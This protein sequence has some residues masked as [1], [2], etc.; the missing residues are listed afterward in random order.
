M[1]DSEDSHNLDSLLQVEEEFRPTKEITEQA[2]VKSND[3]YDFAKK[4]PEK[5]W[6]EAASE[7]AWFRPWSKILEWNQPDARWFIDGK[8]NVSFNCLDRHIKNWRRNKVAIFWEGELGDSR[9]LTYGHLYSEVSKFANVLK[10]L[11]LKKGDRATIYM[12]MLPELPISMLAC[13]R[14][15]VIH[16]VVFSGLGVKALQD[17]IKDVESKILITANHG[18]RRGK[19]IPLKQNVDEALLGASTIEKVV[20]YRRSDMSTSIKEGRDYWWHDLVNKT[21]SKCESEYLDSE[22]PLFILHTS[23]TTGKPKGIVHLNGGYLVGVSRTQKWVFDIKDED[24]F[25]CTADIGWITGHSYIVYGPLALGATEVMYE[26]SPDYPYPD[27]FWN[28]IEKYGVTVF[29]TAPTAI[30][31]FMRLGE[32]W[33]KKHD[34]SSLRLLGTVGEPINMKAWLWYRSIIGANKCP[35]VDTW[36]QTETGMIMISPLP[37]VTVTKPGSATVP[38]PG[39]D[40]DVLDEKG[41]PTP[42]NQ[43]GFL[44]IKNPWPSMLKTIYKNQERYVETYWNPIPGVYFTGDSARK[45]EKGYFWIMGRVDD[46]IKVSGHRLGTMELEDAISSYPPVAES[47]VVGK[48]HSI[49]GQSITA[50]V[51]LKEGINPNVDLR[52]E[53]KKYV[54]KEIGPIATPDEIFFVDK[55]PK[56]R[57]GKIMRRVIRALVIGKDLGDLTTLEDPTAVEEV[58][59]WLNTAG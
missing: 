3:I 12:P 4:N 54:R 38:F 31:E 26:G 59:K 14:I 48:P 57:S 33:P 56:T 20:I 29:Y 13:A 8:I 40:A 24:I 18:Y 5:F 39:I 27:R 53:I 32:N 58:K 35:I 9:V 55:I 21:N 30:R 49:K 25:W 46:V 52:E 2:W 42:S 11:G 16:S 6:A 44:V 37:G 43:G 19:I 50:Y 45:D 17:R 23:G 7:L 28:I 15:G 51:V 1:L 22:D 41:N 10:E 34:L 36:W 47:A